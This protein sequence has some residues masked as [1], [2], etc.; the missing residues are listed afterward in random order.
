MMKI[1]ADRRA[2][3]TLRYAGEHDTATEIFRDA[4]RV[5]TP[6]AVITIGDMDAA[7]SAQRVWRDAA[8]ALPKI[9]PSGDA[10]PGYMLDPGSMV[11]VSVALAGRI[12]G[13]DVQGKTPLHSP[14][15]CGELRVRVGPLVVIMDDRAAAE[16]QIKVWTAAYDLA[17]KVFRGL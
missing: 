16:S 6:G 1:K 10:A 11:W 14:S 12:T 7:H 15:G 17:W 2:T 13:R 9:F 3:V 5:Y 4:V 8:A